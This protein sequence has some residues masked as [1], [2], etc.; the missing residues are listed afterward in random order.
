MCAPDS[1][2]AATGGTAGGVVT[3]PTGVGA[4]AGAAVAAG[5]VAI[6]VHGANTLMNA[7][8]NLL[9]NNGRVNADG[10]SSEYNDISRKNSVN[11]RETNVGKQEFGENLENSGYNKSQSKSGKVTNYIK[12]DK[13]YSVRDNAKSTGGLTADS[14]KDNELKTKIRLQKE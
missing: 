2:L 6:T 12:G 11:N 10:R 1:M 14:F 8:D 3:S 5:G 13:K 7:T 9:N 4:V